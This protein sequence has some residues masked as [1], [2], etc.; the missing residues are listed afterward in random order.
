MAT[1]TQL[2]ERLAEALKKDEL[3]LLLERVESDGV[4]ALLSNE[5]VVQLMPAQVPPNREQP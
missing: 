2:A 1:K 4:D 3:E 5:Q